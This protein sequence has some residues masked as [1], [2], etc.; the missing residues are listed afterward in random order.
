MTTPRR[1]LLTRQ[2]NQMGRMENRKQETRNGIPGNWPVSNFR[3]PVSGF[4]FLFRTAQDSPGRGPVLQPTNRFGRID[5]SRLPRGVRKS[6]RRYAATPFAKGVR[7]RPLWQRAARPAEVFD[8]TG[9]FIPCAVLDPRPSKSA[10][11]RALSAV[12]AQ[13]EIP[14]IRR[15][16][17]LVALTPAERVA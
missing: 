13:R 10:K 1:Q 14:R 7:R 9:L 11:A 12:S 17:G 3:F 15:V 2:R 4:P 5:A 16:C 8:D 6:P